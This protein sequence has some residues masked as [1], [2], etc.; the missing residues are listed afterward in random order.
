MPLSI[1]LRRLF[2]FNIL[3]IAFSFYPYR[4]SESVKIMPTPIFERL[5][6]A[7]SVR[8]IMVPVDKLKRADSHEQAEPLHEMYDVVPCPASGCITGYFQRGCH[9]SKPIGL[10]TLISDSTRILPLLELLNRPQGFF[11]VVQQDGIAGYVHYSD[12]NH[13]AVSGWFWSLLHSIE[14]RFSDELAECTTQD[15]L[16]HVLNSQRFNEHLNKIK[17]AHRFHMDLSLV[18]GLYLREVLA[19]AGH[20]GLVAITAEEI[21]L[22]NDIRNRVSHLTGNLIN[23]KGEIRLL[24]DTYMICVRILRQE[25]KN[26]RLNT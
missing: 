20:H 14:R 3:D 10:G 7:F 17:E 22:L 8:D 23:H 18:V 1:E 6:A 15:D 24:I 9:G 21:R 2:L 19:L 12:L 16:K 26:P 11:F 5:D 13:L 25:R 4:H